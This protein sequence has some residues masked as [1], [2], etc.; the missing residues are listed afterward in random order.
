M[1]RD[2]INN[3]N[4]SEVR[5]FVGIHQDNSF[6]LGQNTLYIIGEPDIE[7]IARR[8]AQYNGEDEITH[9]FFG[10]ERSFK[11][12]TYEDMEEWVSTIQHFLTLEYWSTL[13]LDASLVNVVHETDLSSWN[14]FIP[15]ISVKIPYARDLGYNAVIKI[16]D[17]EFNHSNY[18]VWTHHIHNL[19]SN[20]SFTSWDAYSGDVVVMEPP[21][22][23][24]NDDED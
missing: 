16:D 12:S 10:A 6:A 15:M 5:F 9:L 17:S 21:T 3:I 14:R 11:V 13:E 4:H 7:D 18:G 24:I 20:E 2:F 1:I 23:I 8:L 19:M 22:D